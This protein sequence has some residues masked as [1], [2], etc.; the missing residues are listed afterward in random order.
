MTRPNHSIRMV[1][2]GLGKTPSITDPDN[3]GE[4]ENQMGTERCVQIFGV[5]FSTTWTIL[6]PVCI[7]TGNIGAV[8]LSSLD[9]KCWD[10]CMGLSL[11]CSEYFFNIWKFHSENLEFKKLTL[12]GP[13]HSHQRKRLKRRLN[14]LISY[15][16]KM[17]VER[18]YIA[19]L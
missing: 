18:T 1:Q 14:L 4:R 16:L 15:F 5:I 12:F 7:V 11:G 17:G 9:A 2:D 13:S 6:R 3:F 8:P 19:F 10:L